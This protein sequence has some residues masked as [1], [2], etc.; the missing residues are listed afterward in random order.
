MNDAN[1]ESMLVDDEEGNLLFC[2]CVSHD[3]IEW[4]WEASF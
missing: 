2:M 4:E 3:G 1:E